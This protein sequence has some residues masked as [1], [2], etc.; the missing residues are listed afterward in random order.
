MDKKKENYELSVFMEN[1]N[2]YCIYD[3]NVTNLKRFNT[4]NLNLNSKKY[5][6]NCK[7]YIKVKK[8][9][10]EFFWDISINYRLRY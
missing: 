3:E 9:N 2:F 4:E 7:L 1:R 10:I 5:K 6:K 8:Q